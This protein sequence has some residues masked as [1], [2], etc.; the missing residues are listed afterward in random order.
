[1]FHKKNIQIIFVRVILFKKKCVNNCRKSYGFTDLGNLDEF[2]WYN[3]NSQYDRN[4]KLKTKNRKGIVKYFNKDGKQTSEQ[5]FIE[6]TQYFINQEL[7]SVE[8]IQSKPRAIIE[9]NL[10][11][12]IR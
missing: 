11:T 9:K 2:I 3:S 10:G 7:T 12:I 6:R 1:M 4:P 8:K 5:L